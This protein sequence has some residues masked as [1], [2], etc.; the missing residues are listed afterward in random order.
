MENEKNIPSKVFVN[1]LPV[2]IVES[3]NEKVENKYDKMNK[4]PLKPF[5]FDFENL[6]HIQ[7]L[8]NQLIDVSDKAILA[9]DE[10][11]PNFNDLLVQSK[12]GNYISELY[13]EFKEFQK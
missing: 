10:C 2:W 11:Y 5:Y 6:L 7:Y 3:T 12:D 9:F 4:N 8:E 13:F 1:K